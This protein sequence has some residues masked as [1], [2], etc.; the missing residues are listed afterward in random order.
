MSHSH[1]GTNKPLEDGFKKV[2]G[3]CFDH[4]LTLCD[5]LFDENPDNK[6][7]AMSLGGAS[8]S[9]EIKISSA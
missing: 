9:H 1:K 5:G 6:S 2:V 4:F 8:Q 7:G 3:H